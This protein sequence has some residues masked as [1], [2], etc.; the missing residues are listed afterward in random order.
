MRIFGGTKQQGGVATMEPETGKTEVPMTL[1]QAQAQMDTLAA[2]RARLQ[3]W[4]TRMEARIV[5]IDAESNALKPQL[6]AADGNAA[7]N[8]VLDSLD[9]ERI[10][11]IRKLDGIK[12]AIAGVEQKL[13]PLQGR[14]RELAQAADAERQDQA[15]AKFQE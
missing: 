5:A 11:A 12:L 6:L 15:V 4:A 9:S 10:Q 3:A 1:E 2:D 8:A 7:A 13:S 14:A